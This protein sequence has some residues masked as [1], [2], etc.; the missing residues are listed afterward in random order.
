MS[1]VSLENFPRHG[2]STRG[3]GG[4]NPP[5][6]TPPVR[7]EMYSPSDLGKSPDWAN[8]TGLQEEHQ[9]MVKRS[10]PAPWTYRAGYILAKRPQSTERVDML[11][12]SASRIGSQLLSVSVHQQGIRA[13]L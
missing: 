1:R 4:E 10:T 9:A 2:F 3:L 13:A 7:A 6:P 11:N 8:L 12:R 5:R